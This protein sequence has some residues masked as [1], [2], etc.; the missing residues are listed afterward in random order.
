MKIRKAW[1]GIIIIGT[2]I[3]SAVKNTNYWVLILAVLGAFFFYIDLFKIKNNEDYKQLIIVTAIAVTMVI[4][5]RH[6][7]LLG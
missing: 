6:F 2:G 1:I 3:S 5:V 7:G 4:A